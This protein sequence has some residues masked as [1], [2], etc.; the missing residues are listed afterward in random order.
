VPVGSQNSK[1]G[2]DS[3]FHWRPVAIP[4]LP[5]RE[6]ATFT[7]ARESFLHCHASTSD[8]ATLRPVGIGVGRRGAE[9]AVDD[10]LSVEDQG[11]GASF[12]Q[13]CVVDPELGP[14]LAYG[15]VDGALVAR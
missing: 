10:V 1:S 14:Q 13:D 6:A 12:R 4:G 8:S 5:K 9:E 11:D 7:V 2:P 3:R 15:G